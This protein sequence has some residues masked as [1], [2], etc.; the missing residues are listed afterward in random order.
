MV[1][2]QISFSVNITPVPSPFLFICNLR[3]V[4]VDPNKNVTKQ[5]FHQCLLNLPM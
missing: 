4:S 5:V 1:T 2:V 3:W